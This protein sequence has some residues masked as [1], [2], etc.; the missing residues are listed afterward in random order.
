MGYAAGVPST[1]VL[2]GGLRQ[3]P[4]FPPP[5][6]IGSITSLSLHLLIPSAPLPPLHPAPPRPGP[7][8]PSGPFLLPFPW[9]SWDLALSNLAGSHGG[10]PDLGSSFGQRVSLEVLGVL[11]RILGTQVSL[12]PIVR[13]VPIPFFSFCLAS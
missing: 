13:K 6:S 12:A 2:E 8:P 1:G 4:P 10:P 5:S 9:P 11:L 3:P 7:S